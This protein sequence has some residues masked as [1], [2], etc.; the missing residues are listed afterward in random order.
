MAV[1]PLKF[2]NKMFQL[3]TKKGQN[4]RENASA[5]VIIVEQSLVIRRVSRAHSGRY[6]C[7]AANA[8]GSR[9]SNTVTLRV[10][11]K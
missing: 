8:E 1:F 3:K 7:T 6:S 10:M 11:C 4:I 9:V 2:K 5:G